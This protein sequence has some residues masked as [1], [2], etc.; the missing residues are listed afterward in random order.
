MTMAEDDAWTISANEAF[1]ISLV[2]PGPN[3]KESRFH[4]KFTYPIFGDEEEI[5]GYKDLQ[6]NLRYNATDMRPHL[7]VKYSKKFPPIGD[8]EALDIKDVLSE[9]LP[10]VA[11][12]KAKDWETALA[13]SCD[14]WTPPGALLNDFKTKAGRFEVWKGSLADP[15][16]KQLIKRIQILVPFFI[17]GGT[18]INVDEPDADRW[19][20]FF[21]YQNKPSPTDPS[22][23]TYIF[24]GYSTVYRFFFLQLPPSPPTTPPPSEDTTTTTAT[25]PINEEFDLGSSSFDIS[26]LPCRSRI[27]QFLI[28]P[29]FQHLSLGSRLYH[30][31][32]QEYLSHPPTK[33]ITVEDPNEAFDDM[34]D[35][36]DLRYLRTLPSFQALQINTDI[37]IHKSG[38][39]PKNIIDEAA[40]EKVRKAAKIT[41]RQFYRVLEMQLMSQLGESV[42]PGFTMDEKERGKKVSTGLE[43]KEYALWKLL[44]KKRLYVHNRDALGQLELG[45]RVEKLEEVVKGV[46]FDY[47]RLLVKVE[48]QESKQEGGG[49]QL[50]KQKQAEESNG[51]SANGKGKRKATDE[52]DGGDE[53]GESVAFARKKHRVG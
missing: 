40:A 29:P 3:G 4:P 52:I 46:E 37:S 43:R 5:F 11:F 19:T 42:R 17:E 25:G 39:V 41:S 8:A 9:F 35:I 1:V 10:E 31:I 16:V 53:D 20:V 48:D 50:R 15:A 2:A 47:A 32:Y 26:T 27:S 36:N 24:A 30:T 45:E 28:I 33:E 49:E 34:R 7:S 22:K 44:L 23:S 51:A 14:D 18:A 21:L 12:Q 6:I 38:P 13:K